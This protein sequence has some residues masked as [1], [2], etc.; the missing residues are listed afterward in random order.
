M[1]ADSTLVTADNLS[2]S[3]A[4]G[5][6]CGRA[7]TGPSIDKA[8]TQNYLGVGGVNYDL[9]LKLQ[10]KNPNTSDTTHPYLTYDV[11]NF[12]Y[13]NSGNVST[14]DNTD[15]YPYLRAFRTCMR[16]DPRTDRWGLFHMAV[17]PTTDQTKIP[18]G[19]TPLQGP[20]DNGVDG[21]F[22]NNA[23]P[24]YYL[25]QGITIRP[26]ATSAYVMGGAALGIATAPGWTASPEVPSDVAAGLPRPP[27]GT[28]P[29]TN[30]NSGTNKSGANPI[31]PGAKF[32]YADADG[33][34]RRGSG[35]NFSGSN[36]FP[37]YTVTS[38]NYSSRPLVLN[39]AF[40]SV[41][42]MGYASSGA[43]WKDLDFFSPESGDAALLD[44]FC[45]NE[46]DNAPNDVTVAGRVN[47][48]T[49]QPKVLQAL[50][51]GVSK[52]EGGIIS[53]T[54]AQNA[55]QALVNW[56]SDTTT[57]T[58]GILSKGPLR[59]RSELVGKFVYQV[60]FT[61]AITVA[62]NQPALDGIKSYQGFS[63]MLTAQTGGVFTL[64]A[65][66]SIKRRCESIMRALADSGNT[67]T[68]NLLIDVVAQTGQYPANT[69]DLSKFVVQGETRYWVH[70]SIDRLTGNVI[71]KQVEQVSE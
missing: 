49:K 8:N 15:V 17:F 69:T 65:D 66:A 25:P 28:N 47:L 63:S 45:L 37:L 41:A 51:S 60:G 57:M 56:T 67:R 1:A 39:R 46:L 48:N 50:I 71:A 13:N 2:S 29:S 64:A 52:V 61:P 18:T 11:I 12:V 40:Q 33:V 42:E 21:G 6:N 44:G 53:S 5:F 62:T 23:V 32:F 3:V 38:G 35:W 31:P 9:K 27:S 55:A 10:Y 4:I 70:V 36:G 16:A 54:E 30:S 7:W 34:Y 26:N 20:G 58:S 59:N 68:W 19:V 22:G 14:V 43:A 24:H